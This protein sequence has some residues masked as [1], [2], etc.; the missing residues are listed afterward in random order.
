MT[1]TRGRLPEQIKHGKSDEN[2]QKRANWGKGKKQ[3]TQKGL[4]PAARHPAYG[5]P[6]GQKKL[7]E[8][9]KR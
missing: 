6:F 3:K 8:S 5:T 7:A 9:H 4:W 2:R 1:G